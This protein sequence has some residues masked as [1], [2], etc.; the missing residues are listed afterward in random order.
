MVRQGQA[1]HFERS[2]KVRLIILRGQ[3]RS[4]Y[5]RAGHRTRTCYTDRSATGTLDSRGDRARYGQ[6]EPFT[7]S[8]SNG[9]LARESSDHYGFNIY[10]DRERMWG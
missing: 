7:D 4:R 1:R 9:Y 8:C 5:E 2:G 6:G 3:A 10:R